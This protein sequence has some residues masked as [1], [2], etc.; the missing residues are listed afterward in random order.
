M[1]KETCVDGWMDGWRSLSLTV[2]IVH[3]GSCCVI[4]WRKDSLGHT[5]GHREDDCKQGSILGSHLCTSWMSASSQGFVCFCFFLWSRGK[6]SD[7]V[8]TAFIFVS[9]SMINIYIYIYILYIAHQSFANLPRTIN[10][11]DP[12]VC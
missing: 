8:T 4:R 5:E 6:K 9:L 11:K 3:G 1:R 7:F 12:E 10:P 2:K